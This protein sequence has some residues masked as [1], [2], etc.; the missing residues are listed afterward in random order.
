MV[1]G[2]SEHLAGTDIR[3]RFW[4]PPANRVEAHLCLNGAE[5]IAE[6]AVVVTNERTEFLLWASNAGSASNSVLGFLTSHYGLR[7]ADWEKFYRKLD[8]A[9]VAHVVRTACTSDEAAATGEDEVAA[10]IAGAAQ[11]ER[12]GSSGPWLD[13]LVA[14]A[15]R[16]AH[17]VRGLA[18]RAANERME[19]EIVRFC[20]TMR[21]MD[22]KTTPAG[23]R[24]RL[25]DLAELEM[26]TPM[27]TGG[28]STEN[29][30]ARIADRITRAIVTDLNRS[31]APEVQT[32][33]AA[34]ERHLDSEHVAQSLGRSRN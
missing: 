11:A 3:K 5:G 2:V 12:A 20:R 30:A 32:L 23:L 34:V 10:L 33:G 15:I 19:A 8:E 25:Q 9:A 18:G 24:S 14:H 17:Q 13:A 4:I 22:A 31:L 1:I 16:T 6:V 26:Q 27:E 29:L 7:M 28:G 21:V